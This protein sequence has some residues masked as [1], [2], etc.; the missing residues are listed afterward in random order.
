MS[1]QDTTTTTDATSRVIITP[2][3]PTRP[4]LRFI[5]G[6]GEGAAGE[7][8]AE[9][10]AGDETN[11]SDAEGEGDGA[12]SG[13][14]DADL[15]D[16]G[17]QA[18]DRMKAERKKALDAAKAA[19]ARAVAAEAALANKDKPAEEVA[20]EAARNEAR[21]EATTA[22]NLKLAKSALRLAAKGVLADP[23]D[24]IA[25][26]DASQF[27]VDD[28]G[29]VDPDALKD[30]IDELLAK[31]PH[32]AAGK[33]NRF[34]GGADQGAPNAAAKSQLTEADLESMSPEEVNQARRDGRLTKL[35]GA[36]T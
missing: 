6:E 1:E 33:A 3:I 31:K 10:A 21:T 15:G 25:F 28:E 35:L 20:L 13:A 19:T 30:A 11:G 2:L 5:E 32:L 34:D 26:I 4:R 14:G 18:I 22:A 27:E 17:K 29:D 36:K 8:E 12:D 23:A 16:K 9:G 24:A 7:G